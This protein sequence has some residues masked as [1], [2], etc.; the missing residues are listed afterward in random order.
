MVLTNVLE[1]ES[2]K[3]EPARKCAKAGKLASL[4][5]YSMHIQ[6]CLSFISPSHTP[7]AICGAY[8]SYQLYFLFL[9][10]APS[11]VNI[12]SATISTDKRETS[13]LQP[14]SL[15]SLDIGDAMQEQRGYFM[16]AL[17][18]IAFLSGMM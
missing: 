1:S 18:T 13:F 4:R 7:Q 17:N 3:P 14:E 16:P 8:F 9:F 12:H 11:G 15:C 2:R 5:I 6:T 10:L